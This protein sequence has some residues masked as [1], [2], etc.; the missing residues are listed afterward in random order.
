MDAKTFH[1]PTFLVNRF[2]RL[3]P[4]YWLVNLIMLVAENDYYDDSIYEK[5]CGAYILMSF[6]CTNTWFYNPW[7]QPY[8]PHP[9]SNTS[10]TVNTLLFFYLTFPALLKLLKP[11]SD[12]SIARL[13]VL[14]CLFQSIPFY[15]V[16]DVYSPDYNMYKYMGFCYLFTRDPGF[17]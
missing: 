9:I 6:S 5:N 1:T 2:C 12:K 8:P 13:I 10:W 15:V 3:A 14:L 7:A 17:R 11:L 4:I 16:W